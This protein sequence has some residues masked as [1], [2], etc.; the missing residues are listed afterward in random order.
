[1]RIVLFC[2]RNE[3]DVHGEKYTFTYNYLE[4]VNLKRKYTNS[5]TLAIP[6]NKELS[7]KHIYDY[8]YSYGKL[9]EEQSLQI[10]DHNIISSRPNTQLLTKLSFKNYDENNSDGNVDFTFLFGD[11]HNKYNFFLANNKI[12]TNEKFTEEFT[13]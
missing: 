7:M 10:V 12:T 8:N 2:S 1:M 11:E 9:I 13:V 5:I 6:G 4:V 3:L